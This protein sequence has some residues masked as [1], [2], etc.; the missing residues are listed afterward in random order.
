MRA[1]GIFG[2]YLSTCVLLTGLIVRDLFKQHNLR[3][4]RGSSSGQATS[5]S[6]TSIL[7]FSI[8]A[9]VSLGITWYYMLSFFSLSYRTWALQHG[10]S[11]PTWP[12]NIE[13]LV[14]CL[15]LIRLGAWLKDVQLFRDAWEVAMESHSRL[16]WS[17]PIFFITTTWAFFVGER[18]MTSPTYPRND[19]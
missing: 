2:S 3:R 12:N 8:C 19:C 10:I 7:A 6:L 4:N 18:G 13:G 14:Q 9:T 15:K 17:Q 11:L 5:S 1:I 16:L